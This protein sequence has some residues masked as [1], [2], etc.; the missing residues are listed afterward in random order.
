MTSFL[1]RDLNTAEG[2][3]GVFSTK[4]RLSFFPAFS[5]CL[6]KLRTSEHYRF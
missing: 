1:S 2:N 4:R 6:T 3:S 5:S